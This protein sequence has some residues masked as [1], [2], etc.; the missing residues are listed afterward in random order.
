M[1]KL[2]IP[3]ILFIGISLGV[4]AQDKSSQEL[5][6]DKHT[7]T[8]SF[9]KAIESYNHASELT[10]EGQRKLAEAYHHMDQN[11]ESEAAYAK[12]VGSGAEGVL[13]VD[14]F[15]F[16][17]VLECEGKYDQAIIQM[18]KFNELNPG[19]LRAKNYVANKA[20]LNNWMKDDG[21]YKVE[22]LAINTAADDFGTCYYTDKIVFSS[23]RATPKM[24]KR[25]D[26][27]HGMPY[28]DLYVAKVEGDQLSEPEVFDKSLNSKLHDGTASFTRDGTFMAFSTNNF[29]NI[30][31]DKVVEL[32]IYFSTNVDGDWS[33]LEPFFL[34]SSDYSV[35]QPFL[36]SGGKVMYF[37]SNMPGGF[38]GA[39]IYRITRDAVTGWGSPENLGEK[40]NTE[41]DEMFPFFEEKKATMFFSSNG[42]FGLG[43]L[44]VFMCAINGSEFGRVY[45]AGAPINTQYDDFALV[46]D[47]TRTE[48]YFSSDRV[49]GSGSDDIYS[50]DIFKIDIGKKL[51][52]IAKDKIGRA[53]PGT[54][55]TLLDDKDHLIDT[56]T[57]K[58]DGA[59]IFLVDSD[60]NFKL[61]ATKA[62]YMDGLKMVNT[63]GLEFI[64]TADVTLLQKEVVKDSIK[65]KIKVGADLGKILKF[66]PD[67]IFF[68]LNKYNIRPDAEIELNYIIKVMNDHPTMVVESGSHTDCRASK[69]YNQK[70]SDK[71]AKAAADFIK[72][73]IS[74][75]ERITSKGY[76]EE[77]LMNGCACEDKVLSDCSDAEHQ[78][79]RR[80]EFIIVKE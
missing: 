11:V 79:N 58:S 41:G 13:P 71:R 56:A 31:K 54:F 46:T 10:T 69:K 45:N 9:N 61:T 1:K 48:G 70:L 2:F 65:E 19:D 28:L 68:D 34:N 18:D 80:A 51:E 39:D 38:G 40:I 23:S 49:G 78:K 29:Q 8:Y 66:N 47:S 25:T 37:V 22:N 21:K 44:D 42:R 6:G 15:N 27:W 53:L 57:T 35:G 20:E 30:I 43:G 59:Y 76:G 5:Q 32:E 16:A 55:I 17:K 52:G 14:Y 33:K 72:K 74:N 67:R 12:L 36:T 3:L 63:S 24:I 75:P 62:D 26:N 50:V 4:V 7:F 60:K 77:M 73:R 64:I